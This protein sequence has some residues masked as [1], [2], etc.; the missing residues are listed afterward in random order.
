MINIGLFNEAI[1]SLKTLILFVLYK[2]QRSVVLRQQTSVEASYPLVS[3]IDRCL[4]V[5]FYG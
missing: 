2:S 1:S 4:L 5:L 3:F